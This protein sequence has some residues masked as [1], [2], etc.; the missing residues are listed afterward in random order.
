MDLYDTNHEKVIYTATDFIEF[1]IDNAKKKMSSFYLDNE[2][3][4]LTTI[5]KL[6]KHNVWVFG[7]DMD[8]Q[9]MGKTNLSGN[10]ALV[11]GA[12]GFGLSKLTRELCDQIVSIPMFGKVNSLNASVSA[13]ILLYESVRQRS[14]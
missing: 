4:E 8:G 6:K 10:V 1:V 5:E 14:K 2:F 13:G 3:K 7:A 9:L 12:E 11:I